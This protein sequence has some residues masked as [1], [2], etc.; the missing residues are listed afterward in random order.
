MKCKEGHI[1]GIHQ[2][3]VLAL[4]MEI[5]RDN[6]TMIEFLKGLC[7]NFQHRPSDMRERER[8]EMASEGGGHCWRM[9]S[10]FSSPIFSLFTN[11]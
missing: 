7:G 3:R 4:Y 11:P 5:M 2:I 6:S 10:A 8:M 9:Q 1:R